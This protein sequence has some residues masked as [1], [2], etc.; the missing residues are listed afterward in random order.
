[1]NANRLS[2]LQRRILRTLAGLTPPF[3]LTGGGALAAVHTRHRDT[4]DLDLF[5]QSQ[6]TLDEA[7]AAVRARLES[8]GLV[9]AV[10]QSGE[11]F[12][13]LEVRDAAETTVV[14]LVADPVPLAERPVEAE[15]DGVR[16][17]VDT[18]HQILVNELCALLS[19][20]ELRDLEDVAALLAAGGDLVR[21][22]SD[23]PAQDGGFSPL[24][25]AWVLRELPIRALAKALGRTAD[26][27]VPVMQFRDEL[28]ER[29]LTQSLPAR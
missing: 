22:L 7:P 8:A 25:F 4:R 1:M 23:A 6:R 14:D 2:P 18:P 28:V 20:S 13:R 19:R 15:L 16:I 5:W 26:S 9:V 29:V 11:A 10:L 21:A 24:T 17:L 3:T 27:V 12:V